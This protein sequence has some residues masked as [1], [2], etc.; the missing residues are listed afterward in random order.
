MQE[1]RSLKKMKNERIM[2]IGLPEKPLSERI[3]RPAKRP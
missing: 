2:E 1:S 3:D